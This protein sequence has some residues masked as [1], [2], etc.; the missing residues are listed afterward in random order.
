MSEE[1]IRGAVDTIVSDGNYESSAE[2]YYNGFLDADTPAEY[3]LKRIIYSPEDWKTLGVDSS[4]YASRYAKYICENYDDWGDLLFFHYDNLPIT[5]DEFMQGVSI[6]KIIEFLDERYDDVPLEY[7][8][9]CK[10]YMGVV[11]DSF[12]KAGGSRDLLAKKCA[13]EIDDF[14]EYLCYHDCVGMALDLKKVC[15]DLDLN[16]VAEK[17]MKRH[18]NDVLDTWR[19]VYDMVN[20]IEAGA[21]CVNLEDL[22]PQI[23][24][25]DP[26]YA[27]CLET[28]N[29][30]REREE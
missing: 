16:K 13:T 3:L 10:S 15:D 24:P 9:K 22:I 21:D 20:L 19:Y 2:D 14:S 11:I 12:L 4:K 26:E 5:P 25:Y 28:I 30:A 6:K 7:E 27:D 18:S 29:Y 1:E 17:L 23:D 8:G